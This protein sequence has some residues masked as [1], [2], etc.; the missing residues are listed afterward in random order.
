MA[1]I[2]DKLAAIGAL[3]FPD[4]HSVEKDLVEIYF[5]AVSPGDV[6]PGCIADSYH[7]GTATIPSGRAYGCR[8]FGT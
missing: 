6:K 1:A 4:Q 3:Q 8:S 2:I 5:G 7:S